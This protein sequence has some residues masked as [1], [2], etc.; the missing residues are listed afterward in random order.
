MS[1]PF[2]CVSVGKTPHVSPPPSVLVEYLSAG[3]SEPPAVPH[4][5]RPSSTDRTPR[6]RVRSHAEG[7]VP[8]T[9]CPFRCQSR[10]LGAPVLLTE[11]EAVHLGSRAC[12]PGFANWLK[13]L[14][15]PRETLRSSGLL[16]EAVRKDEASIQMEGMRGPGVGKG[17]RFPAQSRLHPP[18]PSLCSAA[19]KL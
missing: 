16:H 6:D 15:E 17:R 7:S 5:R 4:T 19:R 18:S 9:P 10:V 11:D 1:L 13:W 8:A 12:L 2:C 14:R 3:P